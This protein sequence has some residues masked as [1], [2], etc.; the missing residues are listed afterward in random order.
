[1]FPHSQFRTAIG[2]LP[3]RPVA[4]SM[5]QIRRRTCFTLSDAKKIIAG[6]EKAARQ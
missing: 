3:T 4:A 2:K 5:K 6:N 1:V